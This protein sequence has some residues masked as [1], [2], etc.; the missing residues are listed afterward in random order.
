MSFLAL[1][2]FS[3]SLHAQDSGDGDSDGTGDADAAVAG[4]GD[5]ATAAQ[6]ASD[7]EGICTMAAQADN[8]GVVA[9]E[10][11]AA[12]AITNA[13]GIAIANNNT[14]SIA[15]LSLNLTATLTTLA[16][17]VQAVTG[18][19]MGLLSLMA[20]GVI[21]C[22]TNPVTADLISFLAQ[23]LAEQGFGVVGGGAQFVGSGAPNS[24][25]EWDSKGP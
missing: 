6:A 9:A 15:N 20:N 7:V 12:V 17:T 5:S 4:I 18:I 13:L 16:E 23:D 21:S 22:N 11:T 1:L 24:A 2:L 14:E 8:S 10:M 19:P 3:L 25:Y